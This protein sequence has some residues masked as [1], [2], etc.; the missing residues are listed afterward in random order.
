MVAS[1][2]VPPHNAPRKH[3]YLPIFYLKRWAG[4]DGRACEFSRP[5]KEIV[6]RRAHPAGTGYAIDL[7]SMQG[8]PPEL[9]QQIEEKFF[10]ATDS[11]A[12]DALKRL[13]TNGP[14]GPWKSEMRSAWYRFLIS[15]RRR[16][17]DHQP[18]A[19]GDCRRR[20][21]SPG[22]ELCSAEAEE[23]TCR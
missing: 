16:Q 18:P 13:E 14:G 3:H 2:I 15:H 4:L 8:F 22:A 23:F 1:L 11:L 9:A 7:Y 20:A 17:G 6:P 21:C 5:F 10:R 12:A 19:I